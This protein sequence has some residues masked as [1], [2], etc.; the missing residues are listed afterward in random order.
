MEFDPGNLVNIL[1]AVLTVLGSVFGWNKYQNWRNCKEE[2]YSIDSGNLVTKEE[3]L[4]KDNLIKREMR[5]Q[6]HTVNTSMGEIKLMIVEL[7][8]NLK[9]KMS[10]K[11][12]D[13]IKDYHVG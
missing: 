10:E 1:V 12:S 5:E 6:F 7:N 3:C 11:F 8:G 2:N 9:E 4:R 13:H